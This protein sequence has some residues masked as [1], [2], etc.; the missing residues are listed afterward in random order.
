MTQ[1]KSVGGEMIVCRKPIP[2]TLLS[3]FL[4]SGKTTMLEHILRSSSHELKIAVIVNDMS[5]LNIDATLV[6]N[7]KLTQTKES[8]IQLQNGCIC[9]TLRDLLEELVKLAKSG[10]FEYV[11]IESTGISEPM[12]V[13]E[14]FTS[15]FSKAM[16]EE[17][18]DLKSNDV[19]REIGTD[20]LSGINL[21]GLQTIAKLD[22]TV[23]VIDSFNMLQNFNT[24]DFLSDRWGSEG[25]VP[26][27]ERT[28]TDLFVDQ[29]EFADVIILNKI[30]T[31]LNPN[32]KV[33][34]GSYSKV[35]VREIVNTGRFDFEKA[36]TGAGWLRSLH[37]MTKRDGFGKE[38]SG[39]RLA[40]KP[41]TE[42]YG[43]SSFV[44]RARC[45]FHPKR[46]Y[47][48]L[49]DKFILI[50]GSSENAGDE[51]GQS[52]EDMEDEDE[53]GGSM[54]DSGGEEWE[55]ED[56][57]M[58]DGRPL[59]EDMDPKVG[60]YPRNSF[61]RGGSPWFCMRAPSSW[62]DDEEVIQA[63]KQDFE[64]RWGDQR[65]E[66]VLIGEKLDVKGLTKALDSALL[67]NLEMNRR[68][69]IMRDRK[70]SL[71]RI[72]EKLERIWEDRFEEWELPGEIESD[73]DV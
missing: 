64:G 58:E 29:I 25:I 15:E 46:L 42:E 56:E 37:E 65:Q 28:I 53:D 8:L 71:D 55:D 34:E 6:K 50:E 61:K 9:C 33:L 19:L 36:A 48:L 2:V 1:K 24:A 3:E 73:E 70:L 30:E 5:T 47:E 17:D 14:T 63:I 21:G 57:K 41:E 10:D 51:E 27:D 67:N 39:S 26:E 60:I 43:I 40:P 12:Q 45:P 20:K 66:L 16:L 68:E 54:G 62:P 32:T 13:A 59:S 35:D 31:S 7:H 23:T 4:G 52:D 38:G 44:Y 22:T 18:E 72:V 69:R 11:V 49:H